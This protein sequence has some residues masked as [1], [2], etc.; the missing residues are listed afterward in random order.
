MMTM[1]ALSWWALGSIVVGSLILVPEARTLRR[2]RPGEPVTL[3]PG[4]LD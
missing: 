2:R 3:R 4:G 1:S